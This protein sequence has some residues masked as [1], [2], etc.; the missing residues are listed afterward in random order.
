MSNEYNNDSN[1]NF[2][3]VSNEISD[4]V[5]ANEY[6]LGNNEQGAAPVSDIA[7]TSEALPAEDDLEN[8]SV[9]DMGGGTASS[10][11][12]W[13]YAQSGG[14]AAKEYDEDGNLT[15]DGM[16]SGAVH[17]NNQAANGNQTPRQESDNAL[18][19]LGNRENVSNGTA[20]TITELVNDSMTSLG[21]FD[22]DLE[23]GGVIYEFGDRFFNQGD[24]WSIG[25]AELTWNSSGQ[26]DGNWYHEFAAIFIRDVDIRVFNEETGQ[27]EI[28]RVDEIQLGQIR[29][30]TQGDGHVAVGSDVTF[31]SDV[32]ENHD[33]FR[34]ELIGQ[35]G[36]FSS[37]GIF[38]PD[39]VISAG[40]VR[41]VDTTFAN[42]GHNMN[43]IPVLGEDGQP[44]LN[45][46]GEVLTV[47]TSSG[48]TRCPILGRNT[49]NG[50]GG[51]MGEYTD[52]F[53]LLAIWVN[54]T[55]PGLFVEEEIIEEDEEEEIE[56]EE[57][58][59]EE[60]EE[61]EILTPPTD[62]EDSSTDPADPAPPAPPAPEVPATPE[63]AVD[64]DDFTIIDDFD[65]PLAAF[66]DQPE[67]DIIIDDLEVP[68]ADFSEIDT[69]IVIEDTPVPL[70]AMPQTGLGDPTAFLFSGLML[71]AFA[72]AFV[73]NA[74]RKLKQADAQAE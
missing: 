12:G 11:D 8:E 35:G 60:E 18:G 32:L 2:V 52:G 37:F 26:P 68:L 20:D 3:E 56:E 39:Y 30:I 5:P 27:F 61:E 14:A 29:T 9:P 22:R 23:T 63:A 71:S 53:D 69:M 55:D 47:A 21:L 64:A 15:N 19:Q 38:L 43:F 73:S 59:E 44:V 13:T 45:E 72:M 46:H 70:S 66:E 41:L 42:L 74:I 16:H 34:V 33:Q 6:I 28:Q 65:V 24:T 25:L 54:T 57:I 40:A 36:N 58:I 50:T 49:N 51:Y 17:Y 10:G 48:N 1:H 7:P 67:Y 31:S 4:Y 62:T